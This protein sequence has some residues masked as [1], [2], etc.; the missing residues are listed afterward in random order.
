MNLMSSIAKTL[1]GSVIAIVSVAARAAQR[2]RSGSCG[3]SRSGTSLT[4]VGSI[5]NWARLIEGTPYCLLSSAVISSSFTNPILTRLKPSLPPLPFCCVSACCSCSGVIS[6][7][8][9]EEFAY[10]DGHEAVKYA[11]LDKLRQELT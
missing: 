11:G 2:E 6:F 9:E 8:L 5:L 1:V 3:P 7:L 10:S 4:M